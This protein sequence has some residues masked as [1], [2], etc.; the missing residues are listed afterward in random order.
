MRIQDKVSV[1]LLGVINKSLISFCFDFLD[2]L[3]ID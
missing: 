3:V 1:E 2:Y